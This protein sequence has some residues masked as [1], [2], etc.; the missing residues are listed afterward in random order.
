M[1]PFWSRTRDVT[2]VTEIR[3]FGLLLNYRTYYRKDVPEKWIIMPYF[4]A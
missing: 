3:N 1:V 2:Q 4:L